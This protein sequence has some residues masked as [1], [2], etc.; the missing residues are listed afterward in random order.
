MQFL[1]PN[2]KIFYVKKVNVQIE[3]KVIFLLTKKYTVGKPTVKIIWQ[4][5]YSP[6]IWQLSQHIC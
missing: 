5:K 3:P 4:C 6:L 2:L 1:T